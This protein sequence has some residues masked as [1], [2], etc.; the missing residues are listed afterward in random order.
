[1]FSDIN[2]SE[3]SVAT[4]ARNVEIFNN[5]LTANLPRSLLLKK[6]E[7]RLRFDRIVAM[8][9]WPR[10]WL[11]L[12]SCCCCLQ[13]RKAVIIVVHADAKM[14]RAND[15]YL[16]LAVVLLASLSKCSFA[17]GNA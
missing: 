14:G 8:S 13:G 4:Y 16:T 6:I 12:C 7:N 3:G 10:S 9:L 5:Q 15:M 17:Q 1:L 2:V 11:T